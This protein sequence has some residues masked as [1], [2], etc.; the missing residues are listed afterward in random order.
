MTDPISKSSLPDPTSQTITPGAPA[1]PTQLRWD[2]KANIEALTADHYHETTQV[3]KQRNEIFSPGDA[4][5]DAFQSWMVSKPLPVGKNLERLPLLTIG[6]GG[7][8]GEAIELLKKHMRDDTPL[9][10]PHFIKEL[11]DIMIVVSLLANEFNVPMH[12][13]LNA[14]K[15]KIQGRIDRG[16]LRGAGDDR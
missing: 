9:D 10:L 13:V 15:E 6:L 1:H 14:A 16:T 7:E 4:D 8:A 12:V 11:G 5:I 2:G 3:T